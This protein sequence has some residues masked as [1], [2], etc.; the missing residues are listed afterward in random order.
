MSPISNYHSFRIPEE[1]ERMCKTAIQ[2][3]ADVLQD[4]ATGQLDYH[5]SSRHDG[6][7]PHANVHHPDADRVH[8]LLAGLG[9]PN[10]TLTGWKDVVHCP[11][12]EDMR[13]SF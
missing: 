6:K 7:G 1:L 5:F 13:Q 8:L 9:D 12:E 10:E 3:F 4:Y 2:D 11:K